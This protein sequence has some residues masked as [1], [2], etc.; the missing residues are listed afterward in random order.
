M[1][2]NQ[3]KLRIF[4]TPKPLTVT[5]EC[6]TTSQYSQEILR[7]YNNKLKNFY[8]IIAQLNKRYTVMCEAIENPELSSK[9]RKSLKN[10][11]TALLNQEAKLSRIHDTL[12]K[13]CAYEA[14]KINAS[15][16]YALSIARP[17]RVLNNA[18]L[19]LMSDKSEAIRSRDNCMKKL[20]ENLIKQNNDLDA[21]HSVLD[22]QYSA[23]WI[24]YNIVL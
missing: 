18:N 22:A 5:Q 13:S 14:S 7:D 20:N 10:S 19:L 6:Q 21:Q 1:G 17:D 3:S 9:D 8:R 12:F 2:A 24:K 16:A 11:V 15:C 4:F 23:I